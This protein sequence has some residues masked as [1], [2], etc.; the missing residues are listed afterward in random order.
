MGLANDKI[1]KG[2]IT[3]LTFIF[4]SLNK[5]LTF[6]SGGKNSNGGIKSILTLTTII[7]S[8]IGGATILRKVFNSNIIK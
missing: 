8:L 1:L 7:A 5:I 2:G 6:L 3:T 4:E